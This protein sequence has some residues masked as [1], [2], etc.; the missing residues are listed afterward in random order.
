[1]P[2][3]HSC[4]GAMTVLL[5]REKYLQGNDKVTKAMGLGFILD[6]KVYGCMLIIRIGQRLFLENADW[7]E[8]FFTKKSIGQRLISQSI[9]KES[10]RKVFSM[11]KGMSNQLFS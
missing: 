9:S 8:T 1:M 4:L 5:D 6:Q 2:I 10:L 3:S 11:K 7:T